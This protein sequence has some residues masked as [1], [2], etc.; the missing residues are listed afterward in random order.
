M[1][2]IEGASPLFQSRI[3]SAPTEFSRWTKEITDSDIDF[4]FCIALP[5][6]RD[7]ERKNFDT[8]EKQ[9][10]DRITV[11]R[12]SL[13]DQ[14]VPE[15]IDA[16]EFWANAFFAATSVSENANVLICAAGDL[17]RAGAFAAAILMIQG[18]TAEQAIAEAE[19]HAPAK[20]DAEYRDF[21][22]QGIRE[23]VEEL[24]P[25]PPTSSSEHSDGKIDVFATISEED[26]ARFDAWMDAPDNRER[27]A[28]AELIEVRSCHPSLK[29]HGLRSVVDIDSQ[30]WKNTSRDQ[31]M[32]AITRLCE[33]VSPRDF[34]VDKNELPSWSLMSDRMILRPLYRHTPVDLDTSII[35]GALILQAVLD[36]GFALPVSES[37]T[38]ETLQ[39]YREL[40]DGRKI[41]KVQSALE[42]RGVASL[43]RDEFDSLSTE[44]E[45]TPLDE[46]I[47]SIKRVISA[48]IPLLDAIM[49]H[50][51]H[52]RER[53][54]RYVLE[55]LP[56]DLYGLAL[57]S[58][59]HTA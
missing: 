10:K 9:S 36:T 14:G 5:E 37:E 16:H 53:Q 28:Y 27:E 30:G 29:Q 1:E 22:L 57:Y 15:D 24:S 26:Q 50:R 25:D 48:G 32:E 4:V 12:P 11:I 19:P 17:S 46:K 35:G 6:E 51:Y 21:L 8:W 55:Q 31:K 39:R 42:K 3:P 20:I 54:R 33:I 18:F 41:R 49:V 23:P 38:A 56:R 7:T 47:A 44:G 43:G 2:Y 45:S 40:L 52:Y 34:S 13:P 58:V 59:S